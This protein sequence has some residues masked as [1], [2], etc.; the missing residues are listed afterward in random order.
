MLSLQSSELPE[1]GVCVYLTDQYLQ[2]HTEATEVSAGMPGKLQMSCPSEVT[3]SRPVAAQ[4][5]FSGLWMPY[6]VYT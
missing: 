2:W 5:H 1:D 6:A 4:Y 3:S